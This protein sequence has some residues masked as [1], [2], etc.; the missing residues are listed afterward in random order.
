MTSEFYINL[1]YFVF[2]YALGHLDFPLLFYCYLFLHIY[3][4]RIKRN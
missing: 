1:K 2:V 3:S 4:N